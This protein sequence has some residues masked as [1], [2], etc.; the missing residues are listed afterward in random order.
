MNGFH[1]S[2]LDEVGK[3]EIQEYTRIASVVASKASL[4]SRI[5]LLANVNEDGCLDEAG[6]ETLPEHTEEFRLH[7]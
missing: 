1:T 3:H 2:R 6:D 5:V 4:P 7:K